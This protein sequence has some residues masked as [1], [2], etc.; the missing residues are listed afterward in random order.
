MPTMLQQQA[1]QQEQWHI[2]QVPKASETKKANQRQQAG[3]HVSP[4]ASSQQP[5]N[6]QWRRRRAKNDRRFVAG[7]LSYY[8]CRQALAKFQPREKV[9]KSCEK[10]YEKVQHWREKVF[11]TF[12]CAVTHSKWHVH[13]P[14]F[15]CTS[16]KIYMLKLRK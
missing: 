15:L 5:A 10:A 9:C 11:A 4:A 2:L 1:Q 13:P 7:I 14:A 8:P 12:S 6:S 3:K 16:T